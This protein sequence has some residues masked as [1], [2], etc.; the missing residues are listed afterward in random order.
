MDENNQDKNKQNSNDNNNYQNGA[1][2][3]VSGRNTAGCLHRDS[4][5]FN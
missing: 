1:E 4:R 3:I 5:F 2:R